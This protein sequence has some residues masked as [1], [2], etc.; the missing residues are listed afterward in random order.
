MHPSSAVAI[1]AVEVHVPTAPPPPT[2][3]DKDNR[4]VANV[5]V[6]HPR[7]PHTPSKTKLNTPCSQ[8]TLSNHP[9]PLSLTPP[10]QTTHSLS[11]SQPTHSLS[12][13]THPL[14]PPT[15]SLSFTPATRA[16][17]VAS[18]RQH[19]LLRHRSDERGSP[20]PHAVTRSTRRNEAT[21]TT[22][23]RRYSP[24]PLPSFYPLPSL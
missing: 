11:L 2:A 5:K 6:T 20:V 4:L 18:G 12:L 9:L 24:P 1:E 7:N 17:G 3:G 22:S 13:S 15:P 10:S 14:K 8:P 16:R 19:L 23:W 21:G